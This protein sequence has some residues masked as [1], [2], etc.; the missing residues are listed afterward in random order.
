[1]VCVAFAVNS[2]PL[3]TGTLLRIT[4]ASERNVSNEKYGKNARL[5]HLESIR[6]EGMA[7]L[8]AISTLTFP[9]PQ[10]FDF[11]WPFCFALL[12]PLWRLSASL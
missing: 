2:L 6:G 3:R 10:V 5:L 4:S 11:C 7:S 12:W 9:A 8:R 1:M